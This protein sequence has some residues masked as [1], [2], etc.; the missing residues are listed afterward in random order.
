MR[1][2]PHQRNHPYQSNHPHG[3]PSCVPIDHVKSATHF[4]YMHRAVIG[5][6][7]IDY[8]GL[9]KAESEVVMQDRGL[10]E[11]ASQW[12]TKVVTREQTAHLQRV[13]YPAVLSK[14]PRLIVFCAITHFVRV[15]VPHIY[16]LIVADQLAMPC[17]VIAL[18][19][20]TMYTTGTAIMLKVS[21]A[22]R[23]SLLSFKA[24]YLKLPQAPQVQS[25]REPN[26]HAM[27]HSQHSCL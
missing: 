5:L 18:E 27:L 23:S 21:S 7:G 4:Q 12:Y 1:S 14:W 3:L 10:P 26:M 9:P 22:R 16:M 2:C 8:L 17:S 15:K 6:R 20:S 25:S 13:P 11:V 19:M 24:K